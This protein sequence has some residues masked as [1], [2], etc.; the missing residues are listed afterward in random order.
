MSIGEGGSAQR[1]DAHSDSSSQKAL[2]MIET[3]EIERLSPKVIILHP[4]HTDPEG[5]IQGTLLVQHNEAVFFL[6][7][8]IIEK[9]KNFWKEGKDMNTNNALGLT[10][11]KQKYLDNTFEKYLVDKFGFELGEQF[12]DQNMRV[13]FKTFLKKE[14][15]RLLE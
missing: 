4:Q 12:D 2:R 3:F 6:R 10:A 14:D 9:A 5:I 7:R 13:T 8:H 11:I 1:A 15:F